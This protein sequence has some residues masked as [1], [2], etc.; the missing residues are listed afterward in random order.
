MPGPSQFNIDRTHPGGETTRAS[1]ALSVYVF[2]APGKWL[3]F[4][5]PQHRG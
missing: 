4:G 2:T 1:N 3:M 5:F